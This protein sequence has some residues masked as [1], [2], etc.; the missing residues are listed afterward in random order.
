M[1]LK[2]P[3]ITPTKKIA[4]RSISEALPRAHYQR[5]P[6]CDLLFS[7]PKMRS[8][9]SAYCPRCQAKIRD[10]RDWSLTRLGAMAVTMLLLMPFAW[11]EPLLHIYLLGI[12]IDANVMQGIWQMTRQGDPITAAM[13]LFCVAGAP[14][15]LVTSI[16]YLWFGNILGMNLRPVLLMLERLKEWVML[17]IYLVGI[18]VASIKVQDYAFLQPG[19]GLYAFIALVV[20][21]ILT[22]SHLNIEQLWERFY[23]QRPAK[24]PDEQLRVCLG[25]HFT[26]YPD[27]RGR[28]P[29]CHIPLR[30][31]RNQSIQ[32]CWAALLASIVLLLPANLMPISVI[33]VN[34]GRQE[35][36]IMSGI[37]SLANSNV[38]V[39][40]VVF[41]ASILVPFTKV[42]VMFTLLLSIQ[43][44]C[45]QGLRTRMQLLRLVTWIGR[46][47]MLDLFVIALTMSLINRDQIL[48]FTMGPAAFYFGSAVI[49]T[50]LAVEWLDSRLLWDAHESGN[51]RFAD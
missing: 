15:I 46:W 2:I 48:A 34:G 25:C 41:I 12:R 7:L 26:G 17:D 11:G 24:R 1:A 47:S 21:S 28:C 13:V 3:Q 6:Q 18:G 4:I 45:E 19:V 32:K 50:I 23:P 36:T 14:L 16:A 27:P 30:E 38:A 33:Y 51:A 37:L 29:R 49:L 43:F 22:L 40:A 20:L 39:A 42:I 8:H 10:G 5:C 9:Q 31:R 35:D 44:K